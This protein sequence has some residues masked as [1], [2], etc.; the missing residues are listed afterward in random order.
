M[1][2][3]AGVLAIKGMEE[4]FPS[5]SKHIIEYGFGTVYHDSILTIREQEIAS[6]SSLVAQGN[7]LQLGLHFISALHNNITEN[8]LEALLIH[9]IPQV[10]VPK[11]MSAFF[12]LEK[13]LNEM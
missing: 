5:L 13:V 1:A 10:G 6:I 3:D 7:F 4:R 2:G 12:E 9:C 8:E 11:V